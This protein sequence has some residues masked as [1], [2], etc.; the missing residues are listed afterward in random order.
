MSTRRMALA[1]VVAV[2]IGLAVYVVT[3]RARST[4]QEIADLDSDA[5]AGDVA[6]EQ[7]GIWRAPRRTGG[8]AKVDP[9]GDI[10]LEGQ[11][12]DQAQQPVAGATVVLASNPPR[13]VESEADGSFAFEGVLAKTYWVNAYKDGARSDAQSIRAR[14]TTEPVIIRMYEGMSVAIT[15]LD[16][17]TRAPI[18]GAEV[19]TGQLLEQTATT[20]AEGVAVLRGLPPGNDFASVEAEGYAPGSLRVQ[21]PEDP[22]GRY[23]RTIELGRGASVSGV[24]LGPDGKGLAD[25]HVYGSTTTGGHGRVRADTMADGTWTVP[26]VS[27]GTWVFSC[28]GERWAPGE[29]DPVTVDGKTAVEGVEIHLEAGGRIAGLVVDASGTPVAHASVGASQERGSPG[30]T[31]SKDDGSFEILGLPRASYIVAAFEGDRASEQLPADV[32]TTD[33]TDLRVTIADATISGVVVDATGEPV[34]EAAI[35]A[36]PADRTMF[37]VPEDTRTV[38]DSSGRWTIGPVSAPS[39]EVV[40]SWPDTSTVDRASARGPTEGTK[41]N[42][43]DHD[44]RVV[45]PAAATLR[46]VVM[47]SGAPVTRYVLSVTQGWRAT[48]GSSKLI[49]RADGKFERTGLTP[50]EYVVTIAGADFATE[51]ID[52]VVEL[53]AGMVKDLGTI[54]VD[55][56]RTIRGVVVDGSGAPVADAVVAVASRFRPDERGLGLDEDPM[57]N[58][59]QGSRQTRTGTD[60]RFELRAISAQD[61]SELSVIADKPSV[62]RSKR[63]PLPAGDA[64]L[65]LT[66]A[67]TGAI[68]V[69]VDGGGDDVAIVAELVGGGASARGHRARPGDTTRLAGLVPGTYKVTARK[70]RAVLTTPAVE[71]AVESGHTAAASLAF[72]TGGITVVIEPDTACRSV[73]IKR[74]GELDPSTMVAVTPCQRGVPVELED[75]PAGDYEACVFHDSDF[76]CTPITVKPSPDRQTFKVP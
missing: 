42:R 66:L 23:E 67:A 28:P 48:L 25:S 55:A 11:V 8:N 20:D 63:T 75:I 72:P 15:V 21:L 62:G 6:V 46:G 18:A 33:I 53:E 24:V 32:R 40:A 36:R 9:E 29:S 43:G 54:E 70:R 38:S 45:L 59:M 69:T 64:D 30:T 47:R 7:H 76:P 74:P 37:Y 51:T 27:A 68:L 1:G 14:A 60:G 49:T 13:I 41:A 26:A 56:G 39:Y 16:R 31:T 34:G 61:Q 58:A 17:D 12:I 73:M 50:G 3:G 4:R 35:A 10:R 52:D 65:T 5:G 2:L 19:T 57:Q 71:V 22:G 44:V